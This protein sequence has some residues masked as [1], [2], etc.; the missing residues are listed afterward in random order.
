ERA[1]GEEVIGAGLSNWLGLSSQYR[2][3]RRFLCRSRACPISDAIHTFLI[4]NRKDVDGRDMERPE[5]KRVVTTNGVTL[6][7]PLACRAYC[8]SDICRPLRTRQF[9]GQGFVSD[10]ECA[11]QGLES[12]AQPSVNRE[13]CTWTERARI[14]QV[15]ERYLGRIEKPTEGEVAFIEQILN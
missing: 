10:A 9:F 7:A 13:R 2:D 11:K 3:L 5:D 1:S 12:S 4:R 6:P 15:Q 8:Y 14:G